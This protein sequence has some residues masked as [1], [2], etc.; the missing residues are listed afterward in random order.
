MVNTSHLDQN[1]QNC[2]KKV[3]KIVSTNSHKC[4]VLNNGLQ[5]FHF[6]AFKIV[7][8]TINSLSYIILYVSYYF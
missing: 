5:S 8:H 1:V 4:E 3:S 2:E 7:M 6:Q